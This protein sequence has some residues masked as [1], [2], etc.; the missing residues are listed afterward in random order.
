MHSL[1]NLTL[2]RPAVDLTFWQQAV[3]R[4]SVG[5]V[6][7]SCLVMIRCN[8]WPETNGKGQGPLGHQEVDQDGSRCPGPIMFCAGLYH[9]KYSPSGLVISQACT[10]AVVK[11]EVLWPRA[12]GLCCTRLCAWGHAV[13]GVAVLDNAWRYSSEA[14]PPSYLCPTEPSSR[15]SLWAKEHGTPLMIFLHLSS[16]SG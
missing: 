9:G 3:P 12:F 6:W 1:S 2:V 5:G 4:C 8:L 16:P 13:F 14:K 11:A 7:E 15:I 10:P